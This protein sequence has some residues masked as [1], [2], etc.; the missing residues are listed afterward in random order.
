MKGFLKKIILIVLLISIVYTFRDKIRPYVEPSFNNIISIFSRLYVPC[1]KT[2]TYT[3]GDFDNHFGISKEYFLS[4]MKDAEAIWE[5]PLGQDF[6]KYDADAGVVKINLVYD[7][8]QQAT[9]NLNSLGITVKNNR[10]SYDALKAKYKTL[11]AEYDTAKDA[12]ETQV[13]IFNQR[14][15]SYEEEVDYWNARGGAPKNEYEKLQKEQTTLQAQTEELNGMRDRINKMASEINSFI[16]VLNNLVKTLNISVD[17][18]NT[19]GAS[20]GETFEEGVYESS[21]TGQK[22]D[23]YEFD[24]REKLVR[25]LAHE[26]GHALGLEHVDDPKAIMYKLNESNKQVLTQGDIDAFKAHCKID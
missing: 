6:F 15:K 7:V 13:N 9:N 24:S 22:I 3:I 14:Q 2:I 12:Y 4:A 21:V 20:R 11:Q 5:K 26:F 18:Y 8:R 19:V 16:I 23:I 10:D 25:L 17:Q 1:T